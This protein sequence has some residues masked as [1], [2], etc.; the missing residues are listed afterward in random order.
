MLERAG[1]G[2]KLVTLVCLEAPLQ[3]HSQAVPDIRYDH[4]H[5]PGLGLPWGLSDARVA[6]W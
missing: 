2:R 1:T 3:P 5:R 4:M 6:G